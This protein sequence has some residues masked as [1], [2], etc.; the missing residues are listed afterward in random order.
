[1]DNDWMHNL[2]Q[3]ENS[4]QAAVTMQLAVA[5]VMAIWTSCDADRDGHGVQQDFMSLHAASRHATPCRTLQHN[6][7]CHPVLSYPVPSYCAGTCYKR[8]W[9][10]HLAAGL[11]SGG[12]R[13]GGGGRTDGRRASQRGPYVYIYIYISLVIYV[14]MY[15]Y[16]YIYEYLP[17]PEVA[18]SERKRENLARALG[19]GPSGQPSRGPALRHRNIFAVLV[20]YS[21]LGYYLILYH[22]IVYYIIVIV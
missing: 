13:A 22:V 2:S 18:A 7:L 10:L 11:L 9:F 3:L 8:S 1:M 12:G 15:I 4:Q 20:Y 5:N 17:A 14:C 16:I 6:V 21:Q 19:L